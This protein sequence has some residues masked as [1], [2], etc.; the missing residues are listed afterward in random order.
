MNVVALA[1]QGLD[2]MEINPAFAD[3]VHVVTALLKAKGVLS[4][5]R[6]ALNAR[7]HTH[8]A[9]A[10]ALAHDLGATLDIHTRRA[11]AYYLDGLSTL[12]IAWLDKCVKAGILEANNS[13][14]KAHGK[15]RPTQLVADLLS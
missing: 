13:L 4:T 10:I 9:A 2:R 12:F 15:L 3:R 11:G 1:Q 6:A 14:G 7:P 8:V 5:N